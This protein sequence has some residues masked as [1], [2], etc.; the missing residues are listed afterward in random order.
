LCEEVIT[1]RPERLF[2]FRRSDQC[3]QGCLVALAV[4]ALRVVVLTATTWG[5]AAEHPV[6]LALS[7]TDHTLSI[8]DPVIPFSG[9]FDSDFRIA[10]NFRGFGETIKSIQEGR[11]KTSGDHQ[12]AKCS[13]ASWCS[14]LP[15]ASAR[16]ADRRFSPA[17][18]MMARIRVPFPGFDST[19]RLPCTRWTRSCMLTRPNPRLRFATT[20]S[21]PRPESLTAS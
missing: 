17:T 18:G 9:N 16:E 21:K 12:Q 20:T 4:V 14:E 19:Y 1:I 11:T 13:F 10:V 3:V 6:L 5:Q 15:M 7:K 2:R 8:V